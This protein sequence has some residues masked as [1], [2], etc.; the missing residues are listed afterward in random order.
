MTILCARCGRSLRNPV[1]IGGLVLGS[2]CSRA[3][4]GGVRIERGARKTERRTRRA[5][6]VAQPDQFD[7]FEGVN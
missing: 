7:L 3:V 6:H 4:I 5:A 1:Y 2:T